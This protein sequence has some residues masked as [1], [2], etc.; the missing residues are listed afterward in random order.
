MFFAMTMKTEQWFPEGKVI[1]IRTFNGKNWSIVSIIQIWWFHSLYARDQI[2]S[3]VS[4]HL[5]ITNDHHLSNLHKG[6]LWRSPQH[7]Q[8]IDLVQNIVSSSWI[9]NFVTSW[10]IPDITYQCAKIR[11]IQNDLY[12]QVVWFTRSVY[13]QLSVAFR[14]ILSLRKRTNSSTWRTM[15]KYLVFKLTP[16]VSWKYLGSWS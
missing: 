16:N 11:K 3:G 15:K 5:T 14:T 7:T 9:Y 13:L 4:V 1:G 6:Y 8:Q 12:F 10:T 2:P